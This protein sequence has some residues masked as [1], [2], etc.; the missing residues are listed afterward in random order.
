M[1]R[2]GERSHHT[3]RARRVLDRVFAGQRYNLRWFPSDETAVFMVGL[4]CGDRYALK[5][6]RPEEGWPVEREM[7]VLP[8]IRARGI[9]VLDVKFS[10]QDFP[11]LG[12]TFHITTAVPDMPLDQL[13]FS[14]PRSGS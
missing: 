14:S 8:L 7:V 5:L 6:G 11:E 2:P 13:D 9:P 1:P 10:S 3:D 4:G 12:E